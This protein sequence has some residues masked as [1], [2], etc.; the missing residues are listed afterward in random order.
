MDCCRVKAG[1]V[2]ELSD[3]RLEFFECSLFSRGGF[4]VIHTRCS[5][6]CVKELELLV[7]H[8]LLP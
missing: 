7:V 2:F 8:F 1:R 6:K 4:S 3:Q 5:R